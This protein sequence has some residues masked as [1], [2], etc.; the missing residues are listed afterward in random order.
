MYGDKNQTSP[1]NKSN[2]RKR[3]H[4]SDEYDEGRSDERRRQDDDVLPK[5]KRNQPKVAEAYRYA[6]VLFYR[7]KYA[8]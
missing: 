2:D 5:H 7:L 3:K 8:F 6:I 1:S 4:E